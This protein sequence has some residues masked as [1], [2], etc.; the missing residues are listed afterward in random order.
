M[1][2]NLMPTTTYIRVVEF[3]NQEY[4]ISLILT[5]GC[6]NSYRYLSITP[7]QLF[8]FAISI[9]HPSYKRQIDSIH[10]IRISVK[11]RV[12]IFGLGIRHF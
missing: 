10:N 8:L 7:L 12:G 4:K 11:I 3:L 9:F 6:V 2:L 1:I 5:K